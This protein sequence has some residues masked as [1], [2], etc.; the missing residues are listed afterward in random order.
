LLLQRAAVLE[1]AA[2]LPA[3]ASSG[4]ISTAAQGIKP[5]AIGFQ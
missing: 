3:P 5:A 1:H 4:S 2:R